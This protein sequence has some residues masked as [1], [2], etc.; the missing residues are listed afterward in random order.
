MKRATTQTRHVRPRTSVAGK[1]AARVTAKGNRRVK[2]ARSLSAGSAARQ[3]SAG[4]VII[5]CITALGVL[6]QTGWKFALEAPWLA[7][8]EVRVEG[9]RHIGRDEVM[10][11]AGVREGTNYFIARMQHGA[12][13]LENHPWVKRA[14]MLWDFPHALTVVIEEHQPAAMVVLDDVWFVTREGH[15]FR[16]RAWNEEISGPLITGLTADETRA[17][18]AGTSR[19]IRRALDLH[20]AFQKSAA[21]KIANVSEIWI[22]D[23]NYPT[24]VMTQGT[25]VSTGGEL[26]QPKLAKLARVWAEL[27][28]LQ[29]RASWIFLGQRDDPERVVVRFEGAGGHQASPTGG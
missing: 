12:A 28:R 21:S 10:R 11:I 24:L 9:A 17:D 18:P 1:A 6:V 20:E 25:R 19:R 22:R 14:S 15:I 16:R 7:L 23:S 4:F 26:T 3:A 8:R 5:L 13:S 29:R 2:N 27:E